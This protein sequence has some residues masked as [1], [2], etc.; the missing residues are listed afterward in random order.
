MN[1]A[2]QERVERRQKRACRQ[3]FTLIEL[4]VVVAII[5]LLI[6]ILLPSLQAAREQ[7]RSA[8]CL[9]NLRSIGQGIITYA[10]E[11]RD[12]VP[13]PLHP[14]V[15]RN[16]GEL[17]DDEIFY[18][19]D[20][21]TERPWFLLARLAPLMMTGNEQFFEYVDEVATCPTAK[22]LKPDEEFTPNVNGNPIWSRPYNYLINSW[23]NT[24]PSYYFGWT[25][26]GYTWEGWTNADFPPPKKITKIEQ[27]SEEWAVGDAWWDFRRVLVLPG[28]FDD[29]LLGTWQLNNCPNCDPPASPSP[30]SQN[31]SHNPLPRAPYHKTGDVTN[32]L[33]FDGHAGVFEGVD[34]W[35]LEFPG[36]RCG[37]DEGG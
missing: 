19:M 37:E 24:V 11:E 21:E 8:K 14:P 4:L 30:D 27:P 25:N 36:N 17:L 3:A 34:E 23:C 7:A 12:T 22:M 29:S 31:G 13:G 1:R 6:A 2:F 33:F 28:V 9:A 26:T 10:L 20:E 5:A 32:L 35:A 15:F 16:T 18:E